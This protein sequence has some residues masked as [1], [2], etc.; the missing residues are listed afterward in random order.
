MEITNF[1]D[2]FKSSIL[3]K[4]SSISIVDALIGMLVALGL[5]CSFT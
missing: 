4:T 2:I 1:K 5:Y 3:E